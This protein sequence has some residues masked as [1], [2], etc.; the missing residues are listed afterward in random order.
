M[1][2][3]VLASVCVCMLVCVGV[4]SAHFEHFHF[5]RSQPASHHEVPFQRVSKL[6]EK[7]SAMMQEAMG[8]LQGRQNTWSEF[9]TRVQLIQLTRRHYLLSLTRCVVEDSS[10]PFDDLNGLAV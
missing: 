3:L 4:S 6:T 5:Q 9:A 2:D 10:V 8:E 7:R 1:L